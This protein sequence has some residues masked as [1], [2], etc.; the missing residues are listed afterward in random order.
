VVTIRRTKAPLAAPVFMVPVFMVPVFMVPVFMV[1]VFMVSVFMVANNAQIHNGNGT[2][3][4]QSFS[5]I[6]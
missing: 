4:R 6:R 5:L 1:S 2:A 3:I